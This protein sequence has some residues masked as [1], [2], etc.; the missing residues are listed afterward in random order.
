MVSEKGLGNA[1]EHITLSDVLSWGWSALSV[2]VWV[3]EGGT[4][5]RVGG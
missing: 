1:A 5:W 4:L 3:G 2:G